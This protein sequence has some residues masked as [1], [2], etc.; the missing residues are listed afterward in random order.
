MPM[1]SAPWRS[2]W[3]AWNQLVFD[4]PCRRR[5]ADTRK[6]ILQHQRENNEKVH[7]V[8]SMFT[9]TVPCFAPLWYTMFRH[10]PWHSW[11]WNKQTTGFA[12]SVICGSYRMSYDIRLNEMYSQTDPTTANVKRTLL[13]RHSKLS[14]KELERHFNVVDL[15]DIPTWQLA[16]SVN[17]IY[18]CLLSASHAFTSCFLSSVVR[19]VN[20]PVVPFTE[21]RYR[22]NPRKPVHVYTTCCTR[23][24]CFRRHVLHM[25]E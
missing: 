20:S 16:K 22:I 4:I 25:C 11:V 18:P 13:W 9:F 6:K 21:T 19:F 23:V 3:A 2:A 1:A 5:R 17:W 8:R 10:A 24:T 7:K 14:W 15:P 12:V